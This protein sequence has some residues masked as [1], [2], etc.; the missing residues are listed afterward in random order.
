MLA[1]NLDVIIV[2]MVPPGLADS[3]EPHV[4]LAKDDGSASAILQARQPDVHGPSDHR[5]RAP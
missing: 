3:A 5:F 2:E 4:S 1:F